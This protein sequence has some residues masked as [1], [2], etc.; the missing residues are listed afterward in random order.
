M[1]RENPTRHPRDPSTMGEHMLQG[2]RK[3]YLTM[4]LHLV[5]NE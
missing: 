2:P 5:A 4:H 3:K 1:Y